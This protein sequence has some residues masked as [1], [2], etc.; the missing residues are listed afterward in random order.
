MAAC[1]AAAHPFC[2][3]RLPHPVLQVLEYAA[4]NYDAA[5]VLKTDDDAFINVPP[6]IAQLRA[7][8]ENPGCASERIYMG[9]MAKHSEVL[10]QPGHKWNNLAFHDHTGGGRGPC[11]RAC[12][13]SRRPLGALEG[14]SRCHG[15]EGDCGQAGAKL[16]NM[17]PAHP[18]RSCCF[19]RALAAPAVAAL[20]VSS[21]GYPAPLCGKGLPTH[22]ALA[23][24]PPAGLREYPN[25]MMGGGYV[26]S[27]EV[28]RV[29]VDVHSRM[30]LKVGGSLGEGAGFQRP[31]G[32]CTNRRLMGL[33]HPQQVGGVCRPSAVR[34]CGAGP[35]LSGSLLC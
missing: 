29:L 34:S 10:L 16:S 8:C 14:G 4:T 9:R 6:M 24:L 13:R 19:A 32:C 1:C 3:F 15:R 5:F 25:Y 11:W 7:L 30:H 28:A 31:V 26:V 23:E 27:G 20:L 22:A 21:R 33:P 35:S 17:Q 18:E 12:G 2:A